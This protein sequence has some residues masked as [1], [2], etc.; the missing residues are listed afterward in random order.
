[1]R[2]NDNGSYVVNLTKFSTKNIKTS[3]YISNDVPSINYTNENYVKT[4][5]I[6][7]TLYSCEEYSIDRGIKIFLEVE[8][9]P[10]RLSV[11]SG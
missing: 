4:T 10:I 3:G 1:M 5:D 7:V 6:F 11:F 2:V 9:V 8:F